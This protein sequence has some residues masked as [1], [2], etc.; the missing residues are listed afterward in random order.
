MNVYILII[1]FSIVNL[2]YGFNYIRRRI[3]PLQFNK[4]LFGKDQYLILNRMNEKISLSTDKFINNRIKN[5]LKNDLIVLTPAG[6]N[7]FYNLGICYYLKKNYDLN[8]YIFSGASAGAWNSLFLVFKRDLKELIDIILCDEIKNK[9]NLRDV[10]LE[11]K[12]QIL[13]K[14][15]EDDFELDKIFIK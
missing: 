7:G 15:T 14:Y 13:C 11:L 1:F 10:Q 9:K 4:N 8:N 3:Q 5:I 2:I 6:A 12:K